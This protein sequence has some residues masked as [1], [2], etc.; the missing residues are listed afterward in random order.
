M[1]VLMATVINV[2]LDMSDLVKLKCGAEFN[3][4]VTVITEVFLYLTLE[5]NW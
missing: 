3:T 2:L 4:V 5:N 1:V